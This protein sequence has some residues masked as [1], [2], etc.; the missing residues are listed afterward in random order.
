MKL[1]TAPQDEAIMSNVGQI[2]EFR[3]R[4]S[5]KAFNILSSGLYANKIKAIVRELSCNAVDSHVAAGK[6]DV[7]FEVHLPNQL[8]P[9]FAI[10]D[11]GTGL[12][13]EQVTNIYTTYFESTKT[14]SNEFIGALGLGS[15]SPFSYTDNFTVTAIQHGHKGIYSA[16]INAEGVPSIALMMSE[17]TDEPN[18]VEVKFSVNDRYDFDKFR[19]EARTVYRWFALRPVITG[20]AEFS[21]PDITYT[22]LNI[23]PGVNAIEGQRGC[24]A[25]MGNIAY[26]IEVPNAET[27]L[28]DLARLLGCGLE[29]KFAIGE[30]DFQ[31]S[32][33]GLSYI[34]QTIASIKAKLE[35][36]NAVLVERLTAEA[37]TVKNQWERAFFLDKKEGHALWTSA[38][39][40]YVKATDFKLFTNGDGGSYYRLGKFVFSEETLAKKFNIVLK[41]FTKHGGSATFG[42]IK[43]AREYDYNSPVAASG[44]R[45]SWLEFTINVRHDIAFVINDTKK[46]ALERAKYHWKH[47]GNTSNGVVYVLEPA[48]R[49]KAVNAKAFFKALCGPMDS[50]K[51]VA[52]QLIERE[53]DI[54]QRGKNVQ[55]LRL[56]RRDRNYRSRRSED[57]VWRDACKLGEFDATKTYY[58]MPL[59]GYNAISKVGDGKIDIKA[60]VSNIKDSGLF[61]D[62]VDVY[63][64]RKVDLPSVEAQANWVNLEDHI[65]V[66]LNS[67]DDQTITRMA[68]NALD[69]YSLLRYNSV[70]DCEIVDALSPF[71]LTMQRTRGIEKLR[72]NKYAVDSLVRMYTPNSTINPSAKYDKFINDCE[73]VYKQYPLLNCIRDWEVKGHLSDLAAYVNMIDKANNENV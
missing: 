42:K 44:D 56:E 41:G 19:Q 25:L 66:T 34:P 40:E 4:N 10:R 35:A 69:K 5:A 36:V 17:P 30:L 38:V 23:I 60:V 58:Y 55:I 12:N 24:V 26:P 6:A 31:A 16:F 50:T 7:P 65:V 47:A 29:M 20:Y 39:R 13:H 28:G 73:A 64:V 8:E 37:D 71:K 67:V 45:T 48:D 43:P 53:R 57:L 11:F 54:A 72:Y 14:E 70:V 59:S 32:R 49:T 21:I 51:F 18:G 22:D 52:S 2:G 15:K 3:I 68:M 33:E 1:H 63:G 9:Y 62:G 46:G 61:G 27:N